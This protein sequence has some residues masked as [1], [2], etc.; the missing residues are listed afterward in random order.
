MHHPDAL[1]SARWSRL[2][3]FSYLSLKTPPLTHRRVPLTHAPAPNTCTP[4]A[5]LDLPPHTCTQKM[6]PG[7]TT[8]KERHRRVLCPRKGPKIDTEGFEITKDCRRQ[9]CRRFYCIGVLC[10][11]VKHR[12][13]KVSRVQTAWARFCHVEV[14]PS[15]AVS[16]RHYYRRLSAGL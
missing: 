3:H 7:G 2:P 8:G 9:R 12:F 6:G 10:F 4:G 15:S 16:G 11:F 13:C 14:R 1:S 5:K